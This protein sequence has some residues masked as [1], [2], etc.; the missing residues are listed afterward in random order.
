MILLPINKNE[1]EERNEKE[2]RNERPRF[3]KQ[4]LA[5]NF[6]RLFFS[7][8]DVFFFFIIWLPLQN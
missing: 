5:R 6:K 7:L 4:E 3:S 1:N 8:S 2:K